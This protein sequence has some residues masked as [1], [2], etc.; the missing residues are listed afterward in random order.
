MACAGNPAAYFTRLKRSSSTA[1]MSLPSQT[2]AAEAF[3]WYAL[4]PSIFISR[5][6]SVPYRKFM[7][8]GAGGTTRS[9][10]TR[11]RGAT[12]WFSRQESHLVAPLVLVRPGARPGGFPGKKVRPDRANAPR[13]KI[14]RQ[15]RRGVREACLHPRAQRTAQPRF[16]RQGKRSFSLRENFLRQQIAE[17]FHQQSLLCAEAAARRIR[18]RPYK[19]NQG[20]VEERH[21]NFQ[22]TRHAHGIGVAQQRARHVSSHLEPG[23]SGNRF[24]LA[25]F[26]RRPFEP[27]EPG[28]LERDAVGVHRARAKPRLDDSFELSRR[29]ERPRE[30]I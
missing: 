17:R 12:R 24:Q 13:E 22:R 20:R 21:A 7:R 14:G 23:N 11:T 5:F 25:R 9:G 26:V 30:K 15:R 16:P 6:V 10:R 2:I 8:R 3:P 4:I 27:A 29:E 28:W 19:F 18:Q 1:A